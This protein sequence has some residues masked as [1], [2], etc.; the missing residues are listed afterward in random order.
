FP[1]GC[2]AENLSFQRAAS[3]PPFITIRRLT[4]S[5]NLAGLLRH[6]VSLFRA[7]G[8]HVIA[9]PNGFG[10]NQARKPPTID[11]F[12]AHDPVHE[13]SEKNAQPPLRFTFHRFSLQNLNGQ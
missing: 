3:A 1:P 11:S 4:I 7:E 6:H 9:A 5:S 12:V 13:V 2:V 10:R 8:T